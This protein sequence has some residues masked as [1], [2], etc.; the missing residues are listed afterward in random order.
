MLKDRNKELYLY[1]LLS[2]VL[3]S[4]ILLRAY[5]V[6]LVHDESATFFYYIRTGKFI[7]FLSA[8]MDANN[9]VLNSFLSHYSYLIF[10][11]A[12]WA[13]RLPNVLF[14]LMQ[15]YFVW[16]I[17][18]LISQKWIRWVFILAL[19]AHYLI[20][21]YSLT[22]G[23][24]MS[25]ALMLGAIYHLLKVMD[26]NSPKSVW[27]CCIFLVLGLSANMTLINTSLLI[28]VFLIYVQFSKPQSWITRLLNLCTLL[29]FGLIPIA[30]FVWV[31]MKYNEKGL[32]YY[33]KG[34]SFIDVT[35]KSLLD[36]FT[37]LNFLLAFSLVLLL[38]LA[39]LIFIAIY[40]KKNR[41]TFL[42]KS[43]LFFFLFWGNLIA[44]IIQTTFMNVNFPEDRTALYFYPLFIGM[45]IFY[46]DHFS[47]SVAKLK[48]VAV[49]LFFFPIHFVW[50]LNLSNNSFWSNE[51]VPQRFGDQIADYAKEKNVQPIV[52]GYHM[53]QLVWNYYNL[54][55]S[56][57][58]LGK[59]HWENY[60]NLIPDFQIAKKQDV[61][62]SDLH[63]DQIDYDPISDLSLLARKNKLTRKPLFEIPFTQSDVE[64]SGEYQK[65][66]EF[67]TDSIPFS[68]LYVLSEQ[69]SHSLSTI[70]S[71]SMH[72]CIM[73]ANCVS[74]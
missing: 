68:N 46:A 61:P 39:S 18:K 21:F 33:G 65:I 51:H 20:E 55:Y 32:L 2:G 63:Y 8:H 28:V 19:S 24:G 58:L 52:G 25:M 36:Q 71:P 31:G 40:L 10:G 53:R 5:F 7:P 74:L 14:S 16:K 57:T 62:N 1:L 66:I 70:T 35:A 11:R 23:Y 27:L 4:Y 6:P 30:V 47:G 56:P 34:D 48:Y 72:S 50:N 12:E 44:V 64:F 22:R 45:V 60:P 49:L 29:L 26:T 9:H 37:G 15:F 17:A 3:F 54:D 41:R 69:I 67:S 13:I 43:T 73:N 59:M 38:L 42:S